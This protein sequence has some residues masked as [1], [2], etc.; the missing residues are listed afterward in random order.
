MGMP[1]RSLPASQDNTPSGESPLGHYFSFRMR[2]GFFFHLL[3]A[4]TKQHHKEMLPLLRSVIPEDGVVFDVGAHAGQF[5]KLFA[6]IA[7]K[8]FVF[9][10]EPGTY[11]RTI[12]RIAVRLNGFRNIAILPMA[13]GSAPG[14]SQLSMPVKKSGNYGFGLSY[15]G[16]ADGTREVESELIS[17]TTLDGLVDVLKLERLDFIKADIEGFELRMIEGGKQTL[18]RFKP[19]L[20]LELEEKHLTRAGDTL[21]TAWQTLTGLGYRPYE[22][23]EQRTPISS[24]RSGDILWL[25]K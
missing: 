20:M 9:A 13:L 2:R 21:N 24:P 17:I 22:L 7:K 16:G 18:A 25:A 5:A 19:A 15:V 6:R 8:G 4:V 1:A 11:A 10:C 12:L 23:N 14:V 3:K